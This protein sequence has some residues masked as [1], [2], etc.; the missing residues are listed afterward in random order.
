MLNESALKV[1]NC[2]CMGLDVKWEVLPYR[3]GNIGQ[4]I[5]KFFDELFN[6]MV[7]YNLSPSA[8]KPNVGYY[9]ALDNPRKG[10]F[11]GSLALSHIF[12]MVRSLFPS[13]PIIFDS[14]RGDIA[15][16]SANYAQ[17]AFDTWQADCVTVSPYMGSDSVLP[18]LEGIHGHKGVYILNRTSNPGGKDLQQLL[19]L[20]N[21]DENEM[22]PLYMAVSHKI[23]SWAKKN[24][25]IG[26]VVGATHLKEL[27]EIASYFSTQNIP[28]LI[29]GVGSQGASAKVTLEALKEVGYPINL[30]RIN[31]SSSLTH[32]WKVAPAPSS[33]MDRCIA[34]IDKLLEETAL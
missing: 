20:D 31:S 8:F 28:L 32:P 27:K 18:F 12:D 34:N 17:E 10:E 13:I 9:H 33:W 2:A 15:T 22:Y 7:K 25:N 3:T 16:S 21:V 24:E 19:V 29:P 1:K 26:A 30:G 11:E 6:A 4:D 14:K 5:V 23:A